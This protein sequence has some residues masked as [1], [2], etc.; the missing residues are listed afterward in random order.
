MIAEEKYCIDIIQ[1]N[2]AIIAALKKTNKIILEKHLNTCLIQAAKGK[3][4]QEIQKKI[5][6]I[7]LLFEDSENDR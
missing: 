3:D 4:H 2:R 1:Q 7:L 6:E 5:E